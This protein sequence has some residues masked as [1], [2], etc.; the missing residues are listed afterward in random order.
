VHPYLIFEGSEVAPR[1]VVRGGGERRERPQPKL[2][3]ARTVEKKT[4]LQNVPRRQIHLRAKQAVPGPFGSH[5][6]PSRQAVDYGKSVLHADRLGEPCSSL[7]YGPREH[8][9]RIPVAEA[10]A[11]LKTYPREEV[12]RS[13]TP[14]VVARRRIQQKN[15]RPR[16]RVL[17]S[18]AAGFCGDR[19]HRIHIEAWCERTVRR[20][21]NLETIQ[22]DLG[23]P[24]ARPGDVHASV[25]VHKSVGHGDQALFQV[26]AV[27]HRCVHDFVLDQSLLMAG[28]VRVD[29]RGPGKNIELLLQFRFVVERQ[30]DFVYSRMQCDIPI[31]Q[32]K[33]AGLGN[34]QGNLLF[35]HRAHLELPGRVRVNGEG[36]AQTPGSDDFRPGNGK[37]VFVDN[38]AL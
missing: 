18:V 10:R 29:P 15:A 38:L 1:F 11:L 33:K 28:G 30:G 16:V 31:L 34:H 7:L 20:I 9:A 25:R 32:L 13:E 17:R 5:I 19:L 23:L 2:R 24:L 35:V 12:R 22:Q 3:I 6:L 8:H 36:G 37:A 26:P 4:T 21:V 27:I 14:L